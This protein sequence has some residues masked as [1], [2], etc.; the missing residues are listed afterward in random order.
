MSQKRT[1]HQS[2]QR[3]SH[4][5]QQRPAATRSSKMVHIDPRAVRD[6]VGKDGAVVKSIARQCRGGC[7]ISR[8]KDSNG[9]QISGCFVV[10]AFTQTALCAAEIFL[11]RKANE[12]LKA[13]TPTKVVQPPRAKSKT[14]NRFAGFDSDSDAEEDVT[15]VQEDVTVVQEDVTVVLPDGAWVGKKGGRMEDFVTGGGKGK[16][17]GKGKGKSSGSAP[18]TLKINF[19]T[20]NDIHTR[21]KKDWERRREWKTQELTI[22]ANYKSHCESLP[23]GKVYPDYKIFRTRVL[24]LKRDRETARKMVAEQAKPHV[25]RSD[26]THAGDDFPGLSDKPTT[27]MPQTAWGEKVLAVRPASP[28]SKLSKMG[29]VIHMGPRGLKPIARSSWSD[30]EDEADGWGVMPNSRHSGGMVDN[31]DDNWETSQWA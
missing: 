8:A 24:Q 25:S 20:D 29:S 1:S 19:R 15:V 18:T 12:V 4:Q 13:E 26:F 5:P 3:T 11:Q 16:G 22:E 10:S 2:Q 17:N 7:R 6:V 28:P 23:K 14:E 21:R 30:D 27:A 31:D 9:H